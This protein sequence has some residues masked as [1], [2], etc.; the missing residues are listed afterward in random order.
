MGF[1]GLGIFNIGCVYVVFL[2]VV[3]DQLIVDLSF[4]FQVD[5]GIGGIVVVGVVIGGLDVFV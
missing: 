5:M 3:V 2:L 1:C 4:V